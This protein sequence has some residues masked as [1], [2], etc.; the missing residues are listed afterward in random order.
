MELGADLEGHASIHF[1]LERQVH[2]AFD[3]RF[4]DEQAVSVK[5]STSITKSTRSL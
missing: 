1:S 4:L 5:R 3:F 2:L